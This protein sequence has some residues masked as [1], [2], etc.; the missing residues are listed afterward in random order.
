MISQSELS[1][2]LLKRLIDALNSLGDSS[3]KLRTGISD[4]VDASG[5]GKD[6]EPICIILNLSKD[7]PVELPE[8]WV[9]LLKTR[10][11]CESIARGLD[12][13]CFHSAW[14]V[15]CSH[16]SVHSRLVAD[17]CSRML[18]YGQPGGILMRDP[19]V[20]EKRSKAAS[21]A[22]ESIGRV[23]FTGFYEGSATMP[24]EMRERAT[25][26]GAN[27]STQRWL[28]A[29]AS[30]LIPLARVEVERIRKRDH[31]VAAIRTAV[32]GIA[33]DVSTGRETV[34]ENITQKIKSLSDLDLMIDWITLADTDQILAG[35]FEKLRKFTGQTDQEDD[36]GKLGD[37]EEPD[38]DSWEDD[39]DLDHDPVETKQ[40]AEVSEDD[41][42]A[43]ESALQ[44][45]CREGLVDYFE[46]ELQDQCGFIRMRELAT[47]NFGSSFPS[48]VAKLRDWFSSMQ[49]ETPKSCESTDGNPNWPLERDNIEQLCVEAINKN[50][51]PELLVKAVT[52]VAAQNTHLA[53]VSVPILLHRLD[54]WALKVAAALLLDVR[55][56]LERFDRELEVWTESLISFCKQAIHVYDEVLERLRIAEGL[57]RDLLR[58]GNTE[59]FLGGAS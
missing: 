23:A 4:A 41:R 11:D 12:A 7:E 58:S 24:N 55:M 25:A 37:S 44:D 42:R 51:P 35:F 18:L 30:R 27:S 54:K 16:V 21:K 2:D 28:V 36:Q 57:L 20:E 9:T 31:S 59:R 52:S 10:R 26:K 38:R 14:L 6:S 19:G 13:P 33:C 5:S 39:L 8:S 45:L 50:P 53:A 1:S 46:A 43:T 49:L 3:V 56:K 32:S 47:L 22:R 40:D 29:S 48:P 15:Q 17:L 34:E